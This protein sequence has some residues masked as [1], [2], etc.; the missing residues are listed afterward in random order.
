[1]QRNS[2]NSGGLLL[3]GEKISVNRRVVSVIRQLGEG[4]QGTN[5]I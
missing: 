2:D 1:M 3:A 5:G 4:E